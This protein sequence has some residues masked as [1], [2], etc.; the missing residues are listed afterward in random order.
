MARSPLVRLA[1][2]VLAAGLLATPA[3]AKLY[4]WVDSGGTTHYTDRA[5]EVPP[6]YRDQLADDHPGYEPGSGTASFVVVPGIDGRP[7]EN[8]KAK[9][10]D[11][12]AYQARANEALAGQRKDSPWS[13]SRALPDLGEL[14]EGG[15]P[16]IAGLI[17]GA[18][19]AIAL[20]LLVSVVILKASCYFC[21]EPAPG[22][23]KGM[24]VVL[25]QTLGAGATGFLIGLLVPQGPG[26]YEVQAGQFAVGFLV[27]AAVLRSMLLDSFPKALAVV[28][29]AMLIQ[30]VL[31]LVLGLAVAM[32][33]GLAAL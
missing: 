5:E 25:I 29:V 16:V 26:G 3:G 13:S 7:D 15:A 11:E 20:V 12:D 33:L 21:G 2:L 32:S 17:A 18:L 19:V 28:A 27:N 10:L 22:W 6:R 14:L 24:G 30:L 31:G 9:A 23:G 4:R 8:G 1:W